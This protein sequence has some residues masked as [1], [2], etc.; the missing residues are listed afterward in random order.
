MKGSGS[1]VG[2][3]GAGINTSRDRVGSGESKSEKEMTD[4]AE[5]MGELPPSMSS[6]YSETW[7]EA[8]PNAA[9]ASGAWDSLSEIPFSGNSLADEPYEMSSEEFEMMVNG[10]P[11]SGIE[12]L[13]KEQLSALKEQI[14]TGKIIVS[15]DEGSDDPK[16]P[17]KVLKKVR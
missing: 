3:V 12:P 14:I 6:P 8:F 17:Q 7:E 10:D 5:I 4:Q 1:T 13:S 15:P 11:S 16:P 2:G 9:S